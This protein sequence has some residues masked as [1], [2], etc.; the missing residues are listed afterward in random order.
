MFREL[1]A[2]GWRGCSAVVN[3]MRIRG[4]TLLRR[5]R[6]ALAG[7][8]EGL[9]PLEERIFL[10]N[11][12]RH[13]F[14]S[15]DGE[16]AAGASQEIAINLRPE[17]FAPT[18]IDGTIIGFQLRNPA[19]SALDPVAV[20]VRNAGGALISPL[21]S[22]SD[23]GGK[24]SLV[25]AEL[26]N[27]RYSISVAGQNNTSGRYQLDLYLVGD[28]DGDRDVDRID[29][30]LIRGIYG[31]RLDAV[32]FRNEADAD[33]SGLIDS[34]DMAQHI[35]N[36]GTLVSHLDPLLLNAR[37]TPTP[38]QTM[39][40]GTP[41][42]SDPASGVIGSTRPGV[43]VKFD[44]DGDGFDDGTD[45][46]DGLGGFDFPAT[47]QPGLNTLRVQ[48]T[49]TIGQ[50]RQVDLP[51][52]LQQ[53]LKLIEEDHFRVVHQQTFTV[54]QNPTVLT[55]T[56]SNLNF[57][58]TD[59]F[60]NDAFEAALL[61]G[62]GQS[63]AYAIQ[64]GTPDRDCFFN[65]T[66]GVGTV[67]GQLTT[68]EQTGAG[69]TVSLDISGL[70]PGQQVTLVLRLV[71]NDRDELTEVTIN[72][73]TLGPA[74]GPNL[75][76]APTPQAQPQ[77]LVT[78]PIISGNMHSS[79]SGLSA[80]SIPGASAMIAPLSIDSGQHLDRLSLVSGQ[81]ASVSGQGVLSVASLSLPTGSL[82]D[83]GNSTL[84]VRSDA[85]RASEDLARISQWIAN[86]RTG[87]SWAGL[88]G[89]SSSIA[90][91]DASGLSTLGVLL[92]RDAG[93]NPIHASFAGEALDAN[94]ILVSLARLGDLNLDGL[95]DIDD[96]FAIDVGYSRKLSTYANGDLDFS[97][98][99]DADDYHLMDRGY[100]A[101]QSPVAAAAPTG[102]ISAADAAASPGPDGRVVFTTTA[103]FEQGSMSNVNA[104]EVPDELRLDTELKPY[105]FLW[106]P[107]EQDSVSKIDTR[108]GR[109]LARYWTGPSGFDGQP[110][111]TTVDL[112]GN[113]WV[114]NRYGGSA[115]KIGRDTWIDRNDN[116]VCDTSTDINGDGKI[117]PSEMMPWGQDE[118]VLVELVLIPGRAESAFVPG[119][120]TG[121]YTH[122]W[123]FPGLRSVVVDKN[124]DLWIGG[125]G[126]QKFYQVSTS[127]YQIL[128]TVSVSSVGHHPYGAV[129][130][131]NGVI[132]SAGYTDNAVTRIDPR[133]TPPTVSRI[134]LPHQ[135]YGLGL[136][137]MGHLFV[138]GFD[139]RRLSRINVN[140]GVVEWTLDKPELPGGRGVAV[141]PDGD[142]WAVSTYNW[143]VYRYSNDG[144]HKASIGVGN[145]PTGVA[146][147]ADGMVWVCDLNDQNIH[148][149]DPATNKIVLTKQIVGSGGHYSYSDMTGYV[150]LTVT[151][152]TGTWTRTLDAGRADAPWGGVGIE[153]DLPPG[154]SF[155]ARI[156]AGNDASKLSDLPWIDA[157]LG[158][159][160][161]G[162]RGRHAQV[163]V[164]LQS[165]A[166]DATPAA[167]AIVVASVPAP[168]VTADAI[169]EPTQVGSRLLL[170]GR[171]I[172][173]QPRLVDTSVANSIVRVTING[174]PVEALDSQGSFFSAITIR[175][176]EV[177]Y[178]I[179]ATDAF[180]QTASTSLTIVGQQQDVRDFANLRDLTAAVKG[181][182]GRTSLNEPRDVLYFDM[183]VKNAG[184]FD[185]MG[186]LLVG[187]I[188][189]SDPTVRLANP[190]GVLPDGTPFIDYT[191]LISG[192]RLTPGASSLMREIRFW[193]ANAA[194]FT[195]NLVV[196]GQINAAPRFVSVPVTEA[197]AGRA[198]GYDSEA[199][200]PN[201]DVLT[202]SLVG[203]PQ[204]MTIDPATG[205]ISWTP[206]VSDAG[207]AEV[208]IMADD[209]HGGVAEQRYQLRTIAA[210]ANR[211]PMFVTAP[212]VAA[213]VAP[214]SVTPPQIVNLSQWSVVQYDM[215]EQGPASWVL[216][217]NNTVATQLTNADAS[218]LL[219][220]F[221]LANDRIAGDW[222]VNTSS[223]DDLMGFVFG[224]QDRHH[225]YLFD[226]KEFDQS[227]PAGFS[228]RGMSVKVVSTTS[229]PQ[230]ADPRRPHL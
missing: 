58:T 24:Q 183:G 103:E 100:L 153:G 177:E 150:A 217:N 211:P 214:V 42:T 181:E 170:S 127:N 104:T 112:E 33:L 64:P 113:C 144:V 201:E 122:D 190:D 135:T 77:S 155:R 56:Y 108:T 207:M 73:I 35:R 193:D 227:D 52:Y 7:A 66:E 3:S 29:T 210:P 212:V 164:I 123:T 148:R 220:D 154:T 80:V 76:L 140:T 105:P 92:N 23:V 139:Y 166:Q 149:I 81:R 189:I 194:Q 160:L 71:N 87:G 184:Q 222:R 57:D 55:F 45:I 115:I 70:W 162:M 101:P 202:Y 116:G 43:T 79:Q 91:G 68:A 90:G 143:A 93:G 49:D 88:A 32:E 137:K 9:T 27:G 128:Q 1:A 59:E 185:I 206:Q 208:H 132:W 186:P 10:D 219:S 30:A 151:K 161:A 16:L 31:K 134:N 114:A 215:H 178:L 172:A 187:I 54:P 216:S 125:Y 17:D 20:Q 169:P 102:G 26:P 136:D 22:K 41:L 12:A 95:V 44:V 203:G 14:A 13:V 86:G 223:D 83:L 126:S 163:E 120:Y 182:F 25:L 192:D 65:V 50:T 2:C 198:Y 195:F 171:A 53:S 159:T 21:L 106:V 205:L 152:R 188:D 209:G 131:S 199:V 37:L 228:Q 72:A 4:R 168:T 197:I 179:E 38:P 85:E 109:E 130:D 141:T 110:S 78:A 36:I 18:R 229:D 28:A 8:I 98:K 117:Q 176:G 107:N 226:W 67:L 133:T 39:P 15:F 191:S 146:V 119:T 75:L 61:D 48:A 6:A 34:L 230:A 124:N 218:I 84:I 167:R 147:D 200:D 142:V 74:G 204:G 145:Y 46:A 62:T 165:D 158:A 60:V 111:R 173:M 180:G 118:R 82:L 96:Y 174:T 156:R 51:V 89:I 196:L 213:P 138:N 11:S 129:M 99:V 5:R 19:G 121:G 221:Q 175:P 63:C 97:G 94:A 47:L 157:T 40:D 225:Y 69:G 224:Y